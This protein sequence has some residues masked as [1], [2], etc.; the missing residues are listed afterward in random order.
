IRL[1]IFIIALSP[2]SSQLV[3]DRLAAA[4]DRGAEVEVI[5]ESKHEDSPSQR[6][7]VDGLSERGA[8]IY[9]CPRGCISA[10]PTAIN[11]SKVWLLN[12]G[13]QRTIIQSTANIS[14]ST[15]YEAAAA[16][17]GNHYRKLWRFYRTR[18]DIQRCYAQEPSPT[19]CI[20]RGETVAIEPHQQSFEWQ[21]NG[22]IRAYMS[23][24]TDDKDY[25]LN[26]LRNV[27]PDTRCRVR[28]VMGHWS[29]TTRGRA[30]IK[31]LNRLHRGGCRVQ[32]IYGGRRRAA[33]HDPDRVKV[34]FDLQHQ[35]NVHAK[36]LAV[37]A[38]YYQ[39]R[40]K[41][42]WVGSANFTEDA[43]SINDESFVR[44]SR[45]WVHDEFVRF[46]REI[47]ASD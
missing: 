20:I 18:L 7:F 26:I 24:P 9:Y 16:F 47:E 11:H 1:S 37:N 33:F 39:K 2:G 8:D 44:I 19:S 29:N 41:L 45:D 31:E 36:F 23:S 17:D 40:R 14:G 15:K 4:L 22:T 28:L 10:D 46:F 34:R 13:G 6:A 25:Q 30:F 43:G 32:A 42:V 5:T 12:I 35:T 38:V 21:A 3:F 27:T